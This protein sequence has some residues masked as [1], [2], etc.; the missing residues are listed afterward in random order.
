VD[1]MAAFERLDRIGSKRGTG[2]VLS[3]CG[4]RLALRRD[5]L[6]LP[7]GVL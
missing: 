3:L 1:D 7:I 5:A 4:E 6:C 2:A